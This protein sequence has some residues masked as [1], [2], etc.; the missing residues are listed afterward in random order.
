M[1]SSVSERVNVLAVFDEEGVR[2]LRFQWR[3]MTYPVKQITFR[4]KERRGGSDIHRFAVSDGA[5]AFQLTY[6][7]ENLA[8]KV[9]AVDLSG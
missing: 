6:N 4:W 7:L 9:E 1:I 5:S 8:W 3:G 2:P